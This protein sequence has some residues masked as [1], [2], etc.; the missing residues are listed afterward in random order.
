MKVLMKG[1]EAICQGAINAG[2][3]AFF[4]YPITP[5]SEIPEYMA[6]KMETVSGTFIQAESELAAIH[7]VYGA[8]ATG[9]RA[10]TSSSSPGIAL[11]QEGISYLAG[12]DLP[13]VVVN[14]SR[15]GPGLG[16]IL[17]SQADYFQATRGGGNGDYY[18]PVYAPSTANEAYELTVKAFDVADMY[19]TPVMILADGILGQMMEPVEIN[20][21]EI[22][23]KIIEKNWAA[24]GE[25][26]KRPR[27]VVSSIDLVASGLEEKNLKRFE[28][29]EKIKQN[30]TMVDNGVKNG[31]T[32]AIVAY[33][34]PSRI[35]LN[36]IDL[37]KEQGIKAALIRPITLWP[38]PYEVF[39]N[40]PDSIDNI[41][42]CELS[43]GQMIED[44]KLG[45]MGKYPVHFFGRCGGVIFTPEEIVEKVIEIESKKSK[46]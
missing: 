2:C 37:L 11:K 9:I 15:A 44:V 3:K 45:V 16:G 28:I 34:T 31:D 35:V 13:C 23:S 5:Q 42:V 14:V 33:G 43:M 27:N 20:E 40:L 38:Y 21:N 36:A 29:Y 25:M 12:A 10:M 30:E 19:R 8:A 22:E 1:N 32:I 24:N 39:A 46:S 17:P 6:K 18:L 7:M 26:D 4:G 41:L